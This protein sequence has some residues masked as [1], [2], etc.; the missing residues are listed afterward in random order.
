MERKNGWMC[1]I[2]WNGEWR[3][4]AFV[5]AMD[6]VLEWGYLRRSAK[7]FCC[8]LC[9]KGEPYKS[10]LMFLQ[11]CMEVSWGEKKRAYRERIL[12]DSN[13]MADICYCSEA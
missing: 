1:I 9:G 13:G 2:A 3:L 12:M 11:A 6:L 7:L 10:A 4:L 8:Y 5:F